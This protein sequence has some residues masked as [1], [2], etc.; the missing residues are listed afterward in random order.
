M[1]ATTEIRTLIDSALDFELKKMF[2]GLIGWKGLDEIAQEVILEEILDYAEDGW[3]FVKN[4]TGL[5]VIKK[6]S[7]DGRIIG[8]A[9]FEYDHSR[10]TRFSG[11]IR[12]PKSYKLFEYDKLNPYPEDV[13]RFMWAR[14]PA[15]LEGLTTNEKILKARTRYSL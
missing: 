2:G 4:K 10:F 11:T 15:Y 7:I 6:P 12:G 9:R 1:N 13:R 3:R 14:A 8:Q 5:V